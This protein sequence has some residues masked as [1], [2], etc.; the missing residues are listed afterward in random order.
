MLTLTVFIVS[1][2]AEIFALIMM[3]VLYYRMIALLIV[4]DFYC[5]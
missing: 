4:V 3:F 1:I 5:C 2:I